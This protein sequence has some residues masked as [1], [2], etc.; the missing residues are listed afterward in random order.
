MKLKYIAASLILMSLLS[1]CVKKE[2]RSD[3]KDFVASFSLS[4]SMSGYKHAGYTNV[5]ETFIDG[6]KTLENT[7]LEFNI[8]D[9]SNPTYH[10]KT[11]TK[12]NDGDENIYEK[13]LTKNE[14][15]IYLNETDKEAVEFSIAE[16]ELLIQDFFFTKTMYEGTYH[17]NGMYYG[18]LILETARELQTFVEIDQENGWYVFYHFTKGKVD[19]KD[20]SVEQYYSVNKLGMLVKNISK[21]V[22][23]VNYINQEINV[24]NY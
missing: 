11:I 17:C 2:L 3:I 4:D 1:S 6:T 12:V 24:Y 18:D 14:D 13:F 16:V 8:L 23:G 19:G 7:T 20:S 5:K 10:L 21:Q 22:N 15:K 9:E